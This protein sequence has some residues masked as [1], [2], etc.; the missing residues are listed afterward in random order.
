ME[1]DFY[2]LRPTSLPPGLADVRFVGRSLKPGGRGPQEKENTVC[3]TQ[4]HGAEIR[5]TTHGGVLEGCDG[6]RTQTP[7]L[8]L[9]VRTADCAP[10]VLSAPRAG[11]AILHAGWRGVV[12][13]VV[14]AA[15]STFHDPASVRAILGPAI[16]ACC[17]EVGPEVA[18]QF[19]D[20]AVL[21]SP[22]RRPYV[23]LC[24][25]VMERLEGA[26]IPHFGIYEARTCTRC[27]Q[28][29]LHSHRGSHGGGGRVIAFA[30]SG[31]TS[32]DQSHAS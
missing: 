32:S 18:A 23:D 29:L 19:P 9:T 8:V 20:S 12:A 27:H 24:R 31:D 7:G 4:V 28:H 16:G 10:V 25:A 22:G 15:V 5:W 6:A 17:F 2:V 13:G 26:G 14:E 21:T 1:D 11:V 30:V 3:M